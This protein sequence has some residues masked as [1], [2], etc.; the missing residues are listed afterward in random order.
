M[1]SYTTRRGAR[2]GATIWRA[3]SDGP[4]KRVVPDGVL[5][6][7]WFRDRLV[8]AGPD[9]RAFDA[10]TRTGEV[11]WGLRF[12]PGVAH[13]L[14]GVPAHELANQRVALSDLV[15][16]PQCAGS[17]FETDAADALERVFVA[18]WTRKTPQRSELRVAASLDRAARGGLNVPDTARRHN[19]S[20]R[21]LRRLSNRL[22]GYGPKTL[23]RI[24]RF[25]RAV[26]LARSGAPLG[27]AAARAGYV[28]QA[29]FNRDTKDF[30]G[31]TPATL[32][33]TS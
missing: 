24:H 9:T 30:T 26:R 5:D 32:T 20:E 27:D 13:A 31:L 11:T 23:T 6:L 12:G 22:F 15:T 28:D 3:S 33:R 14:L 19:L 10:E 25:Q 21:S 4:R 16:P 17:S 2:T 8:V 18:L 1:G 7:M 29:H